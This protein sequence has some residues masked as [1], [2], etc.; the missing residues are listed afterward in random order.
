MSETGGR[1]SGDPPDEMTGGSNSVGVAL[2]LSA[3]VAARA[4]EPAEAE[5]QI[6]VQPE[7]AKR[8]SSIVEAFVEELGSLDVH[9]DEYRRRVDDINGLG[10]R[11]IRATSEMSNRL[12]D[13][14]VRAVSGLLE[15]KSPVGRKLIDLR[16]TVEDLNP[17]KYELKASKPRRALGV[18][19]LGDRLRNYFDKYAKAQSHIEGIV[20]SLSDSRAELE[21]DNAAIE[22][23][24][25]GLWAEIGTLRQYAFMAHR[26]D[27]ALEARIEEIERYDAGR[28]RTLRED[29]LFPVRRRRQEILTQLA[30]A[31][32]GHAALRVVEQNNH[33]V[34]RAIKTATT[35]TVAALR[36]AVMVAQALTS[37]RLV[38]EQLQAVNDV[39][40]G[41][42][43]TTSSLLREQSTEVET[44]ATSPGV[45]L[46]ALQRAWDNVFAALDQI[47]S[48][49]LNALAAMKVTVNELSRE[50]ERSQAYLERSQ[51]TERAPRIA[52]G[53]TE[54]STL[55]L[56]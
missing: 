13:R 45:D 19:P 36:T 44:R 31:A 4:V 54:H 21:R 35:T 40:S 24:E 52:S 18:I 53:R 29:V 2:D 51:P 49:K 8:I 50:V 30:V 5:A 48:Y 46:A 17:A 3:P 47:D 43:E 28:G 1:V 32:Q 23:E 9:G 12:L 55:R 7:A 22:Q 20:A 25:R 33:E 15:G 16:H 11:E 56:E 38:V 39:T 10:D 27:E 34:V 26:L 14:P 6:E 37:Q 41:M 42:I